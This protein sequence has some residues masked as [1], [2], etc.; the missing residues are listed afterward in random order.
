MDIQIVEIFGLVVK[1]PFIL[2]ILSHFPK[3][4]ALETDYSNLVYCCSYVTFKIG[5]EGHY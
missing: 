5:D 3:N 1:A 4:P 2:T